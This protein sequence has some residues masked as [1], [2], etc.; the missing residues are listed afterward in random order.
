MCIVEM[1]K[2]NKYTLLDTVKVNT[3]L[4]TLWLKEWV[5]K[6]IGIPVSPSPT[7]FVLLNGVLENIQCV[8]KQLE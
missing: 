8:I 3:L 4:S 2:V 6:V 7:L 5:N 1:A